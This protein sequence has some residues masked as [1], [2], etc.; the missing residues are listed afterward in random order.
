M[1]EI[2]IQI[3]NAG[4]HRDIPPIFIISS[5]CVHPVHRWFKNLNLEIPPETIP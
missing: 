1:K 5:I 3:G 4:E 2:G